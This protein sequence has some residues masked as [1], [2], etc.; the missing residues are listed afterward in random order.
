MPGGSMQTYNTLFQKELTKL[1]NV[2]IEMLKEN[3]TRIHH[4]EGFDF[5][6]YKQIV[7]RIEGL[8]AA[9]SHCEEAENIVNGT[10]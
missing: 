6:S 4:K 5:S 3:L 7:G 1:I 9:L 8:R 10:L 2:E